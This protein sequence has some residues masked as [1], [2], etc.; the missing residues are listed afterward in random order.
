MENLKKPERKLLATDD[1]GTAEIKESIEEQVKPVVEKV[2]DV[3]GAQ[4]KREAQEVLQ[5]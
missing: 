3:D 4:L 1:L 5:K 2:Q